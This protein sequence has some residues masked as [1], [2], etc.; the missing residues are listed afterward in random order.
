MIIRM[1]NNIKSEE[2]YIQN[3]IKSK[4]NENCPVRKALEIFT[5]KWRIYVLFELCK[6]PAFR[7]GELKKKI[8]SIT[9]TMLTQTLRD[10]E[11]YGIVHR[12]QYNEIPPR[13]EYSMTES[14]KALSSVFFEIAKWS[15]AYLPLNEE[16]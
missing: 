15:D 3:I 11:N 6:K 13:V 5:G 8:P 7:F 16:E 1:K 9:N 12:E 4:A 2:E 14:G 10:L